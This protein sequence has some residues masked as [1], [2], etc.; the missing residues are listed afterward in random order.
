MTPPL[1]LVNG[2]FITFDLNHEEYAIAMGRVLEILGADGIQDSSHE[3]PCFTGTISIRNQKF[4]VLDLRRRFGFGPREKKQ[5]S[6]VLVALFEPEQFKVGLTVDSVRQVMHIKDGILEKTPI[7]KKDARSEF[8]Y[9]QVETEGRTIHIL[10]WD[11]LGQYL[12]PFSV[13]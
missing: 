10:N 12:R 3:D 1:H 7:E 9:G 5:N 13:V 8:I 6:A 4:P 2:K 11:Q